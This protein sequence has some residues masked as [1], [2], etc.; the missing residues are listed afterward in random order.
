MEI[1]IFKE[2]I[3]RRLCKSF[4]VKRLTI[5]SHTI[6]SYALKF[7]SQVLINK[8]GRSS[9]LKGRENAAAGYAG[10]ADD[11]Q[12]Y[13]ARQFTVYRNKLTSVNY[14]GTC[15]DFHTRNRT[16]ET[17][18]KSCVCYRHNVCVSTIMTPLTPLPT[19]PLPIP[20]S[21]KP[22]DMYIKIYTQTKPTIYQSEH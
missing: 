22:P 16:K 18:K 2:L 20:F 14:S 19:L 13:V 6:L 21:L 9:E 3:A 17:R 5:K 12:P 7:H 15:S 8:Y 10:T 11:S 4:G 1:L